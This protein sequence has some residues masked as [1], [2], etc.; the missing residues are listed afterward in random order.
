[1]GDNQVELISIDPG[2]EGYLTF[3]FKDQETQSWRFESV[4]MPKINKKEIDYKQIYNVFQRH[5][6]KVVVMEQVGMAFKANK[7][8]LVNMGLHQGTLIGLCIS[9]GI[10]YEIVHPKTWQS[11]VLKH[12]SPSLSS[13]ERS[14]LAINRFYPDL[15]VKNHNQSDSILLGRYYIEFHLGQSL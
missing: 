15:S 11:K 3:W 13:K 9:L 10:H 5:S 8:G 14:L 6:P 4:S 2:R 12:V 7:K 1:M